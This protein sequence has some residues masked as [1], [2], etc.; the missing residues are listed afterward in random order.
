MLR[1]RWLLSQAVVTVFF[2]CNSAIATTYTINP[3]NAGGSFPA[4]QAAVNQ[5]S[6]HETIVTSGPYEC[7][8]FVTGIN[9]V[10]GT[11]TQWLNDIQAGDLIT[12]DGQVWYEVDEVID[13]GNIRLTRTIEQGALICGPYNAVTEALSPIYRMGK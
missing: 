1:S 5:T 2:C 4:I 10:F 11:G 3:G 7:A 13:N 6:T 9:Q 12:H 8:T